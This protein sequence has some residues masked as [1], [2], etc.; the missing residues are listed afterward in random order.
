MTT[1]F[2]YIR[3]SSEKQQL[4]DSVRRQLKLA[5]DYA[6]KHG[7][8]L[9]SHSY[10]DLGV[11][12]FKG[13]N[14]IEGKLGTFLRAV[15]EGVIPSNA[16]L[17]VESLDRLSRAQVDVALEL[18]LSIIRR[19]ITI[20]TLMDGQTYSSERIKQD[21]GM[22]LI[23]SLTYMMRAHEESATKST[24]VKAAWDNK[25]ATYKPGVIF[26][27]RGPAWLRLNTQSAWEVIP[28][29]AAVVQRIYKMAADGWGQTK[30]V[31][32]LN[33]E[34]VETMEDAQHWTQGV[35]GALLRNASAMGRYTQKRGGSLVVE[36]YFPL[37]VPR[38]TWLFVQDAIKNRRTTGGVK[39]ERVNNLFSGLSFCL[40]CGSRTRFV[41]TNGKHSYVHCLRSYSNAG[42]KARPFPY[43]PAEQVILDR[44][45]NGQLR[46]LD[47]K[48][49]LH[50]VDKRVILNEEIEQLKKLQARALET[51]LLAGNVSALADVLKSLQKQIDDVK[52]KIEDLHQLPVSTKELDDAAQLFRR[53]QRLKDEDGPE[54]HELRLSMQQALRRQLRKV[55][56]GPEFQ[57]SEVWQQQGTKF[58]DEK[59]STFHI[60][61][62]P[63]FILQLTFSS[64]KVRIVDS[65]PLINKRSAAKRAS[66]KAA[67]IA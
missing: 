59:R 10:R 60:S 27:R 25:R 39:G 57:S 54:L 8:V 52:K 41:P 24:R 19:G 31:N 37:V 30:I 36:D 2:S 50:E 67:Q 38:E 34:R 1:A 35:V 3:F 13:K 20:I 48:Y 62:E 6:T 63:N 5:E 26:S 28:E 65:T 12:A 56:F 47:N 18:F 32:V 49:D 16:I 15:D 46:R 33:E 66:F 11:S 64:G 23:I 29:K 22:S 51:Q 44:L 45:L 7:L 55:E 42:C 58:F 14:L 4:G 21:K 53:H 40:Y 61:D 17:L 9:D 43:H